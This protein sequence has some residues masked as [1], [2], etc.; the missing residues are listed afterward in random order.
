MKRKIGCV[1]TPFTKAV[2]GILGSRRATAALGGPAIELEGLRVHSYTDF[3]TIA[4]SSLSKYPIE[5]SDNML[6]SAIG[7]ASNHGQRSD[8]EKLLDIGTNPIEAEIIDAEISIKTSNENL[9]VW[10]VNSEGFYAGKID[11]TYA[12]GWLKFHIGPHYPGLYYLIMEE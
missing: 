11:T 6:L 10:S 2:F 1:D 8:G 7:R 12:D 5:G 4:L 3:A 9:R